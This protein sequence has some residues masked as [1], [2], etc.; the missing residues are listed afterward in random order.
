MQTFGAM[1]GQLRSLRGECS[2]Q[3]QRVVA[4][5]CNGEVCDEWS[6]YAQPRQGT[7]LCDKDHMSLTCSFHKSTCES[8]RCRIMVGFP[9]DPQHM[10]FLT[11]HACA[12]LRQ[13]YCPPNVPIAI[14]ATLKAAS[15]PGR[16]TGT[17]TGE[18]GKAYGNSQRGRLVSGR[19]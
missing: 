6:K 3:S 2:S 14:R 1:R 10:S 5:V 4:E 11:A 19:P 12:S 16:Q 9:Y 13:L 15:R 8:A 17:S 7:S 18:M